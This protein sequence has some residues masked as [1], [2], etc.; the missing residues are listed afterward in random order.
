M[1][2]ADFKEDEIRPVDLMKDQHTAMMVDIGR[3]LQH[4]DEFIEVCCPA[5]EEDNALY[6]FHKYGL[7]FV[8]CINCSTMYTNPRPTEKVLDEFYK[9]SVNYAYWNK[10]IFPAS[11]DIRRE[12]IFIPRVD[13]T[14]EICKK[15]E[16]ENDSL[17]EIG[18]AFG[19][20]CTEMT[21][22][23]YFK[24]IVAVEPTPFLAETCRQKGLEVIEDIVENIKFDEN[25]RFNVVANFEVIEHLHSP[26][27]FILNCKKLL[28]PGGLL[29]TTCPNGKG[30][31]IQVL[32]EKSNSVD[33]EHLNYFNQQSLGLLLQNNGF[34]V[35]ESQTPGK[36]DAEL[37]RKK[38][39]SGEFDVSKK[40][41]LYQV[42]IE[43]WEEV[44]EDFQEF[45]TKSEL[46]S[47]M[48]IVAQLL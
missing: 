17:L 36:L 29:F 38:I 48:W 22:R 33:H 10:Y 5:C 32:M 2:N 42:L 1:N 40:P 31:D 15:Y 3:L 14:L 35:L 16:I 25:K 18:A 27:N 43:K 13:K 24:K 20:F 37:V 23:K 46:S 41:F 45:L 30:F 4:A 19:T 9:D 12:K 26:K 28:K 44:G 34:K 21:S 11:E 39:I 47:N 6:Q 8:E 7:Q